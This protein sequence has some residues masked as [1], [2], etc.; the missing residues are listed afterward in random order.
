MRPFRSLAALCA[1]LVG[2]DRI[3]AQ[4]PT[5]PPKPPAP[6]EFS[7][8]IGFVSTSG[9]ST[10]MTLTGGDELTFVHA[11]WAYRQ[12]FSVVYGT[13]RDTVET[14]RWRGGLR[15]ERSFTRQ[16]GAYALINFDKDRFSGIEARLEEGVGAAITAINAVTQKLDFELGLSA[17]QSHAIAGLADRNFLAGR[18]KGTYRRIFS[19]KRYVQQLV[20]YLPNLQNGTD[21]RFNSE[22]AL[23]APVSSHIGLK[24]AYLYYYQH[25]PEFGFG[26]TDRLFSTSLQ[27]SF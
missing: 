14:S 2:A 15:A 21:W 22:T 24:V 9:N 27:I 25:L 7:A 20:E 10:V 13:I 8:D 11:S 4:A 26:N 18:T 19:E 17:V 6:F 23:I 5:A 1:L 16:V 12:T 3:A